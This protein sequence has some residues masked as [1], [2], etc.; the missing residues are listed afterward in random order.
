MQLPVRPV[1]YISVNRWEDSWQDDLEER[2]ASISFHLTNISSSCV[3]HERDALLAFKSGILSDPAGRLD[4]WRQD[5]QD[6]CRW[7]GVHCSNQT[8]TSHVIK[9]EIGNEHPV[10]P[11]VGQ[12]SQSLLLLEHLEHLDLSWNCL[13]GQDG[14]IPE[15]LG[16]L[17][18]L[19]YLNLSG[20]PFSG[21]LTRL[22]AL[23]YLNL[24]EVNLG[25]VNDWA[26]SL[27]MIPSLRVID[28]SSCS[29]T[30]ETNHYSHTSTL[31]T[32]RSL[33]SH[34]TILTIQLHH[35]GFG[36]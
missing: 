17:K 8:T 7:S 20:V 3:P 30:S 14:S 2:D 12:I 6:C 33:I 35:A 16:S 21:R 5:N 29:L 15:F 4:S 19:N 28:L 36:T 9:V 22:H 24:Y 10:A 18:N 31:Q 27:N 25:S 32:S 26:Q 1:I 11:M 13:N 34:I 23:Q